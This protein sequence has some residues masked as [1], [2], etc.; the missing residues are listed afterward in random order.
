VLIGAEPHTAWLPPAL[1]RDE[2]GY[3]VTGTDLTGTDLTGTDL[4]GTDLVDMGRRAGPA[5]GAFSPMQYETS[6][7]GVFAVGDVRHRSVKRVASAVGEG[8]TC[9]SLVHDYLALA[10]AA[11]PP[12]QP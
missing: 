2:W 5:R 9:I 6:V 11:D 8:S 12:Q 3:I 1:E 10:S 7:P 4:T